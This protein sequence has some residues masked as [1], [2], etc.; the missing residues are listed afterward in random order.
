MDKIRIM[1]VED[2]AIT[3]LCIR[4]SLEHLGYELVATISRGAEAVRRAIELKPD[5][6]LMDITLADAMSGI[7]AAERIRETEQ[8]PI[9][10]MTAHTDS[11]TLAKAKKA[12]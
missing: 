11:A 12:E 3:A 4:D 1:L 7:E 10:F 9:I 8:I 6:I 5:L 2:E